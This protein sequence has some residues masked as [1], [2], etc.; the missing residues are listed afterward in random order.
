M[1]ITNNMI[2]NNARVNINGNKLAVDAGDNQMT[3]Q[4]KIQRPSDDPV[5]AVRS[6]RFQTQLSKI[7]QYLNKNITD[8][9][10]WMDITESALN[11]TVSCMT[12]LKELTNQGANDINNENDRKSILQ[13]IKQ[14]QQAIFSEGNADCAGRTVF[15]G[16]RTD[17]NLCFTSDDVNS[18][19]NITQELSSSDLTSYRYYNNEVQVPGNLDEIK[20]FGSRDGLKSDDI[21]I[22]QSEYKRLRLNYDDISNVDSISFSYGVT[23]G[24]TVTTEVKLYTKDDVDKS[25]VPPLVTYNK[26]GNE[27]L[28]GSRTVYADKSDATAD[29]EV[30][31]KYRDSSKGGE[32]VTTELAADGVTINSQTTT[33][34]VTSGNPATTTTTTVDKNG[35]QANPSDSYPKQVLVFANEDD[36]ADWSKETLKAAGKT[37]D[38]ASIKY[39]PDDAMVVI[40]NTGD[41]IFG[42]TVAGD[43]AS[44]NTTVSVNYDKA[45]FNEGELKPEY[46]Y[47]CV[48]NTDL[49][50]RQVYRRSDIRYDI[51]YTVAVN[52]ELAVNIQAQDCFDS[53]ILQDINDLTQAITNTQNAADKVSKLKNML[54]DSA[55]QDPDTQKKL[56]SWLSAAQREYDFYNDNMG[57]LLDTV[58]GNVDKYLDKADSAVTK[59]GCKGDELS[60]TKS[61]MDDQD[62]TV[63]DLQSKND[64]LDISE[65]MINYTQSYTAYQSSLIAAGK[66]GQQSLLNYI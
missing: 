36:W 43:M 12:R 57:K 3:T 61:R 51:N 2:M 29:T 62:Q 17:K 45:G 65:I 58:H 28:D 34:S 64:N 53:G 32:I 47:D 46:Y 27:E 55:Y 41:L 52:Q 56:N 5:V 6:L 40:K 4:K 15:T 59:L 23:G 49:A 24:K 44:K 11:N 8:A 63:K 18:K 7:D 9:E 10:S 25:K 14:L 20:S 31:Y 19:Y 16:Y 21:E 35:N 37:G 30:P 1:R 13:E 42:K 22:A 60:L 26:S 50:N 66:L 38:E 48:D 33:T 54:S 39:V